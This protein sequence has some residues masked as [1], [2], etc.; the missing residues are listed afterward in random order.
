[1]V[2]GMHVCYGLGND[3]YRIKT[4]EIQTEVSVLDRKIYSISIKMVSHGEK[5]VKGHL[6]LDIALQGLAL[7]MRP[8]HYLE[9]TGNL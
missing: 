8:L 3:G 9:M 5:W 2:F 7:M 6:P 4:I 1:M